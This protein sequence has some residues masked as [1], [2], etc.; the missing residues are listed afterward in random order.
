[1]SQ[2]VARTQTKNTNRG[3]V[4]LSTE[5]VERINCANNGTVST[6]SKYSFEVSLYAVIKN[7][8]CMRFTLSQ[9]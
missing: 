5:R 6:A 2:G 3:H 4:A 9:E 8:L 7:V 1:V